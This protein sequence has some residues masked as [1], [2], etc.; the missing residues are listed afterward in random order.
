MTPRRPRLVIALIGALSI[1]C[2]RGR[3]PAPE[4]EPGSVA[5]AVALRDTGAVQGIAPDSVFRITP[6]RPV[7]DLR[8]EALAASPPEEPGPF[9][10]VDLVEVRSL[11]PTIRY[12][13]RYASSRNFM[14]EPFYTSEHAFLQRSAA[15]ALARA[16]RALG[17]RGFGIL[18]YDAYRPWHVTKMFWDATPPGLRG[19][20]ANP[21]D[22]SR[23][24]RGAAAD[25]TLYDLATGAPVS[26]PSGYDEFTVRAGADYPGG[27]PD[28]RRNRALLRSALRAEGFTVLPGEWWHF[29]HR[30]WREYAILNL[31]F[32]E[33]GDGG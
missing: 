24:N 33:L 26:M 14:G 6:L 27:T 5:A 21:A 1:A 19:F 4:A 15:E 11:D 20:V 18:V 9:R 30:D 28:E 32:E 25:V 8:G 29:D 23:H 7:A 10:E 22:G 2:S 16:H 3:A 12:D 17:E 13:I 31:T